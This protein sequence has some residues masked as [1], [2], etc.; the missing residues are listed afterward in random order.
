MEKV[1]IL[2]SSYNGE[3]YISEQLDSLINQEGV[4]VQILVRDDGSNDRTLDIL[5]TYSKSEKLSF[6]TGG[7]LKPARSFLQLLKDA[8]EANY[9]AFCDQDDYWMTDKLKIAVESMKQYGKNEP[10]LYC[11]R[12]RIVDKELKPLEDFSNRAIPLH[13]STFESRLVVR[14]SPG[15]TFVMNRC[16]VN[17]IN[18]IEP[19][20]LEMH[21]CWIYQI[22]SALNGNIIYDDDVHILYRQHGNNVAGVESTLLGRTKKRVQRLKNKSCKRS[23]TASQILDCMRDSL[24]EEQI[25]SLEMLSEYKKSLGS[26]LKIVFGKRFN[27][28]SKS[29]NRNFKLAILFGIF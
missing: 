17:I 6:Y 5:K 1:V 7:N 26:R 21:D 19:E 12:P 13:P 23:K 9:Y 27:T 29:F 3:K 20:F 18:H 2:L 25:K 16:L 15:C 10:I 11:G 28:D 24:N 4:E 22:C 14:N 8:P